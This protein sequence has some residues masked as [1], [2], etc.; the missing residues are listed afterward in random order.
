MAVRRLTLGILLC[1]AGWAA[2]H[3]PEYS[4]RIWRSEDGLP[5]NKIQ[6]ITQ[7]ADGFL[8]IGTS[9][10]LVR[11]DGVRFVVFDRSS[12][13]ALGDDSILSLCPARDGSLWVGTEGGGL[14]R[15]K[16]GTLQAFGPAQGLTNPFIRAIAEDRAGHLWIG[17]DRGFFRLDGTRLQR[18]DDRGN[19]PILSVSSLYEDRSG[20]MRVGTYLGFFRIEGGDL[21]Q[22]FPGTSGLGG[23]TSILEEKDGALLLASAGGLRRIAPGGRAGQFQSDA[24]PSPH[25][26]CRDPEGNLWIGTVGSGLVRI[27][28]HDKTTYLAADTLPDNTVLTL[29]EDNARNLWVG[30]QDGLLRMT[31]SGVK[32]ITSK[33]GLAD[34]NVA[35][36]YE[37][38]SGTLW[39]GTLTGK[40]YRLDG[41]RVIPFQVPDPTFRAR[42]LYVDPT[43]TRWYSSVGQGVLRVRG[44]DVRKFGIRD[45]MRSNNARQFLYDRKGA[46]WITTGS[47]LTRIEGDTVRTFYLEDG[48]AYGGVRVLAEESSG[49]ILVGTD[50][51][52]NRIHNGV[53][54]TDPTFVKLGY[55]RIWAIFPDS[56]GSLWL[57]TRGNG[58]MRIRA[59]KITRFTTRDGLPSNSVYEILEDPNGGNPRFWMSSPAGVFAVDRSELDAVADGRAGPVAVTPYGT[60]TGMLSSQ[61]NGGVQSAG[62][63]TRSGQ[64]WFPSVKGAVRIDPSQIRT[65]PSPNVL[66]ESVTADDR[67]LPVAGEI[68]IPPGR[69]KLEINF[70]APDLLSPDRVT[71]RYRLEPFDEAWTPSPRN[72]AAYYTNLPSGRYKF[73]VIARDGARPDRTSEAILPILW[74]AHSY[75]TWWFYACLVS[76]AAL[77]V[78]A[79]F[80]FY[81]RQTR[82][83]Y[84]LVLAERTRLAREMHDTVIQGCVGVSTLLEAARSMPP[85]AQ[86]RTAELIE[87]AATQVRLTVNEARE[88]VW[89]LRNSDTVQTDPP[90]DLAETLKTFATQAASAEGIPVVA[91][92]EG[93]PVSLGNIADRNLLLV[94]RE[95]IRNAVIHARPSRIAVTLRFEPKQVTLEVADDGSGFTVD[96]P[97]ANAHY[98]IIGMRERVEQSGGTFHM[99][100]NPE[101]GTQVTARIPLRK[102]HA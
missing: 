24:P 55:Q 35:S 15:M 45:G 46:V 93:V 1:T 62:C 91:A 19:V 56:R 57:G 78:W 73:H 87:R 14:V 10:G 90:T 44:R 53:F 84:A 40:M 67:Q 58:L 4:R 63:R 5:Q 68:V 100:S 33:D 6:A 38:P 11:F 59:G 95:A 32:T 64:F 77:T 65:G 47:G 52:L 97:P 34:D 36:V 96:R 21:V 39:I 70:T 79:A 66:I 13:P 41:D 18:L 54:V 29:F 74:K 81:A 12:T 42:S 61:M 28:E 48:L 26:L 27:G 7:T 49:D 99:T 82:A 75:E 80:H 43:G 22:D 50:G 17:T 23:I 86:N 101:R 102:T 83:R 60:D 3:Q 51:G 37:D 20:V 25:S 98:G 31:R 30:T 85:S 88:A 92:I 71:F 8:W 89:D 2:T 72:R 69:G 9:G 76:L 16:G 94:A